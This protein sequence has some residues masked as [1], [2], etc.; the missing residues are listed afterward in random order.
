ML[1]LVPEL[2]IVTQERESCSSMRQK[3][4]RSLWGTGLLFFSVVSQVN[5]C[6]S[7]QDI[8]MQVISEFLFTKLS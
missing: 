7:L 5:E 1:R 3:I 4:N 8:P 2:L 6:L